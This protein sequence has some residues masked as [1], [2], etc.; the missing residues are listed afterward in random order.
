[1]NTTTGP[2]ASVRDTM[3]WLLKYKQKDI[4]RENIAN[5]T[6]GRPLWET[7]SY[8]KTEIQ[9]KKTS[10]SVMNCENIVESTTGRM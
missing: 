6:T 10:A 7:S 4:I 1:M 9:A 8:T 3:P 5:T 2:K